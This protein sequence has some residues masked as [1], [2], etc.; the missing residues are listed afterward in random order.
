MNHETTKDARVDRIVAA[1]K[2]EIARLQAEIA[3]QGRIA[4]LAADPRN[5]RLK[6]LKQ[7]L[8]AD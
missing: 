7:N 6:K 5:T 2:R 8:D 1:A 3:R 4:E